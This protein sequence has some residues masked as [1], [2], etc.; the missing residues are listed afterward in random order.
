MDRCSVD[1]SDFEEARDHP[2][3]VVQSLITT[4]SAEDWRKLGAAR[5]D[6]LGEEIFVVLPFEFLLGKPH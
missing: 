6:D 5:S 4:P 3:R 1:V 2:A